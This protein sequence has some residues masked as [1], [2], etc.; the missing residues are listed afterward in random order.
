MLP[1]A[2]KTQIV[3]QVCAA[4]AA[5]NTLKASTIARREYPFV[6]QTGGKRSFSALAATSVFLHD[7]FIDRYSGTELIFPGALRLLSR[8]LPA[9]F[10]AHPNWKTSESHIIYYELFPTVDHIH[11]IARGGANT[12]DNWATTSMI[13]NSA[14]AN[15]TL[16]ELHWT[17]FPPGNPAAWDGLLH[18]FLEFIA[19][20]PEHLADN[21]IKTWHSAATRATKSD[22][23]E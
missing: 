12:P 6:P 15:W 13:L 22:P 14:K 11:P 3:R 16:E 20:S 4:L 9:E 1:L 7:G 8:L 5:G 23:I 21:Y 2:D 19:R 17:L 10:P 18:W